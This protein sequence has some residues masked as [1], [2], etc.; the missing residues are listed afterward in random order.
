MVPEGAKEEEQMRIGAVLSPVQEWPAFV[1]AAKVADEVGLDAI[2]FW[3]H[4]HSPKPEWGYVCGWSA[5]GFLAAVTS[6]VRFVP[7]VL[8]NLHYEPGVLAKESSILSIASGGRFELGIGAGD[9]P[10]SFA[11]WGRPFPD[12]QTR[13]KLLS[14]TVDALRRLWRGDAVTIEGSHVRLTDA[15]CTPAPTSPPRVVVGVGPSRR[16][17]REAVRYADEVNVYTDEAV[18]AAARDEIARA[19]RDVA[20]S[21]FVGWEF[22]KWP[23]DPAGELSRW[24]ERGIDRFFINVGGPDMADRVRQLAKVQAATAQSATGR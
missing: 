24:S 13:L 6:R 21:L 12:A 20:I 23:T 3:D 15:A 5:Y 2:G 18:V 17:L 7:M 10:E 8:N 19:G 4:Y 9:W 11:A 1:E 14:E 22:E 16:T